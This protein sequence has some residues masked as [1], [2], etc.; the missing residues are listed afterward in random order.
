LAYPLRVIYLLI[1]NT[2][3]ILNPP[4]LDPS[5]IVLFSIS[6]KNMKHAVDRNYIKRRMRE[7]YRLRKYDLIHS[8]STQNKQL[9]LARLYINKEKSSFEKIDRA[10]NKVI[11]T[12]KEIT[13]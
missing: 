1:D 2:G 12:L 9:L 11:Q 4:A 8:L 13:E 6:K 5:I 3:T 10:M 7:S